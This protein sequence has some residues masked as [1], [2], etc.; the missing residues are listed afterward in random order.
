MKNFSSARL[1]TATIIILMGLGFLL[2]NFGVV[3]NNDWFQIYK[4]WPLVLIILGV[5]T[6]FD[7]NYGASLSFFFWGAMFLA[8]T[9]LGWEIWSKIWPLVI[10]WVGL[11]ILFE[12]A[13][14]Q[15][16]SSEATEV[17][18]DRIEQSTL[19]NG[20]NIKVKSDSFKGGKVDTV[21]GGLE[22]D[23]RDVKVDENGATLEV[24]AIF[25]GAEI[26]VNENQRV[27]AS[28]TGVFG[29]WDNHFKTSNE[30]PVLTIK[31]SGVFG[32]VEIRN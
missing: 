11:T 26:Y 19:F 21:F 25:G 8:S 20:T 10:V 16:H 29:G 9:F 12:K 1:I 15:G 22:L 5:K 30:G 2:V 7:R 4:L 3:S 6:L 32:G 23:L 28:G 24:N 13:L 14:P 31:G 17:M 27:Q 18:K